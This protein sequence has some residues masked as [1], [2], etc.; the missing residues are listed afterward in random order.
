LDLAAPPEGPLAFVCEWPI[1][2]IPE[3]TTEIDSTLLSDAAADAIVLWP[4][5]QSEVAHDGGSTT[6]VWRVV[7]EPEPSKPLEPA[8]SDEAS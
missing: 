6:D 5:N 7:L 1:A 2:A 3:T 4:E 8:E